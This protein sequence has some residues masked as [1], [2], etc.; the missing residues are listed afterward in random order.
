MSRD[1]SSDLVVVLAR[2]RQYVELRDVLSDWARLGLTRGVTLVNVDAL[3]SGDV[4][5]PCTMLS[6]TG[7]TDAILQDEL[8]ARVS[9]GVVRVVAVS[10]AAG[11][12][13]TISDRLALD[14]ATQI[15]ASLPTVDLIRIHLIGTTLDADRAAADDVE[16][17]WLGWHNVIV[18]PESAQSPTAGVSPIVHQPGD[19][20]QTL[21]LV[22]CLCSLAG[23]WAAQSTAPLDQTPVAPG[24]SLLV[25]RSFTRHLSTA[26]V[27]SQLLTTL[28]DLSAG[29]PLP[30]ADGAPA[31]ILDDELGAVTAMAVALEKKHPYVF[32]GAR[33]QPRTVPQRQIGVFA[34][35]KMLFSFLGQAIRNAPRAFADR[36]IYQASAGTASAINRAVF[37][38]TDP[39]FKVVVNGIG[40][41]GRPAS[42]EEVDEALARVDARAEGR[43]EVVHPAPADLSA[44]W[45]D[46]LSAGMTLLD[47]GTRADGL[48]PP[49][50]G[51]HRAVVVDPGRVAPDPGAPFVVSGEVAPYINR[52]QVEPTDVVAARDVYHQLDTL[53]ER[54]PHLTANAGKV[55]QELQTFFDDRART[56]S[57]R[58]GYRLFEDIRRCRS[59]IVSYDEQLSALQSQ[60]Q[61][62]DAVYAQQYKL[63]RALKLILAI[64]AGIIVGV[65]ALA[66]LGMV[67]LITMAVLMAVTFGGWLITSAVV[68]VKGQTL[69]FALIHQRQ[70]L[71]DSEAVLLANAAAARGDL[72]RL[73]RAYRQ[74]LDWSRALGAFLKAPLGYPETET[75]TDLL[76]GSRFPKNHRFGSARPDPAAIERSASRLRRDLFQIGWLSSAWAAFLD[77]LPDL[78]ADGY[79]LTESRDLLFSDPA[80]AQRPL[81]TAWSEAVAHRRWRG[82]ADS[83]NDRVSRLLATTGRELRDALLANV[84]TRDPTT[85]VVVR[86]SL[87]EFNGGLD[88]L[89][90]DSGQM[91]LRATFSSSAQSA[92]P[93]RVAT[94][95]RDTAD[96]DASRMIVVT[97]LSRGFSTFDLSRPGDHLGTNPSA[98]GNLAG[99]PFDQPT[100]PTDQP[101]ERPQM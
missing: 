24:Q 90:D 66:V 68:F 56:F 43:A 69:L 70:Q 88:S 83:L 25:A 39:A 64:A 94:T 28:A 16:L 35:L 33:A 67:G 22:G 58:F 59:E 11:Q 62:S 12:V 44:L 41:D 99:H 98:T 1:P 19:P 5:I 38:S 9:T 13:S 15:N 48:A 71:A 77:D 60:T 6:A 74:Y 4:R 2:A 7:A 65:A 50:V 89:S 20:T 27:E 100:Q 86:T 85:G 10:E 57:G 36:V 21:Q 31:E 75:V 32:A 29:Y 95:A 52:D 34:L 37:G 92:E 40:P 3:R 8:A 84:D 42:W 63:A 46:F 54:A 61:A 49:S 97:Q 78:G 45:R 23:L 55:K 73:G 79:R 76:I 101:V 18:S 82:A 30:L 72:R 14:L 96:G 81:L 80:I 53:P 17:A 51:N 93:W 47:A 87:E 91:F 26:A